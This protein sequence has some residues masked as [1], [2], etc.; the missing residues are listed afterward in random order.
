[1]TEVA[2]LASWL[3]VLYDGQLV[4]QGPPRTIFTQGDILR[5]WGLVEP[6]LSELLALLRKQGVVIPEEVFT[7]DEAFE[8][9]QKMRM[10]RQREKY[11]V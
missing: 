10:H 3:Y 7:L 6:P 9:L 5:Q 1:M 2:T 11:H 8:A 4:L